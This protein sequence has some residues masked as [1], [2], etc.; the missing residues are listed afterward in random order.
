MTQ[1]QFKSASPPNKRGLKENICPFS[2]EHWTFLH[3]SALDFFPHPLIEGGFIFQ[4]TF[5]RRLGWFEQLKYHD[6]PTKHRPQPRKPD[7]F[8]PH[9]NWTVGDH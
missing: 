7:R 8:L 2:G 4:S 9:L 5:Q 3:L 1:K 6:Q